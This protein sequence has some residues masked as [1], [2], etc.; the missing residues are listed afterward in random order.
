MIDLATKSVTVGADRSDLQEVDIHDVLS[1]ER[2][3]LTLEILASHEDSLTIREL[4]ELVAELETGEQPPPRNKRQ[5]A[6]VSLQQTHLPKLDKLGIIDY[7]TTSKRA[8]L[9]DRADRVVG[10]MDDDP[11][12]SRSRIVLVTALVALSVL[13][14]S[15]F[16]GIGVLSIGGDL[17]VAIALLLIAG[18]TTRQLR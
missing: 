18:L 16:V 10:Y 4:S 2:R 8:S 11:D 1:N 7:D 14:V 13:V 3:Q 5:S 17:A 15:R 9:T 6:Y 12:T